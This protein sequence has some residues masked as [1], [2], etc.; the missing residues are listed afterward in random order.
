MEARLWQVVDL[1]SQPILDGHFI[2]R[3]TTRTLSSDRQDDY[4]VRVCAPLQRLPDVAWLTAGGSTG[5]Y[6]LTLGF[7][8]LVHA[9]RETRRGAVRTEL[10][11]QVSNLGHQGVALNRH[12]LELGCERCTARA[13]RVFDASTLPAVCSQ[14]MPLSSHK[15]Y[16]L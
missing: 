13:G 14:R 16:N 6:S 9:R 1:P 10:R 15:F 7:P 8:G 11:R 4:G 5:F 12:A 2:P 3:L